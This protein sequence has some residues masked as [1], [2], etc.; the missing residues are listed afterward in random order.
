MLKRFLNTVQEEAT[1][2]WIHTNSGRRFEY[3]NTTPESISLKD[4]NHCLSRIVRFGG[5]TDGTRTV[6]D[7]C[8]NLAHIMSGYCATNKIGRK[9]RLELVLQALIHDAAE[10]YI[11]DIPSP[12]K[13]LLGSLVKDME[14]G[15]EE[16]ICK[17]YKIPFPY[18]PILKQYDIAIGVAEANKFFDNGIPADWDTREIIYIPEEQIYNNESDTE[19]YDYFTSVLQEYWK[20]R[21]FGEFNIDED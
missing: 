10:A 8:C 1:M 19:W 14:H 2:G 6:A 15:I 16:V 11:G 17:K 9:K 13:G 18:N 7:H 3:Y 20:L 12:L 5:H 21:G 4:I